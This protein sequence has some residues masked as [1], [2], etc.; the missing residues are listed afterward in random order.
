MFAMLLAPA[1]EQVALERSDSE[2][3]GKLFWAVGWKMSLDSM[4][5]AALLGNGE[6]GSASPYHPAGGLQQQTY[7]DLTEDKETTVL[8]HV[9]V[10]VNG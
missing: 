8:F 5:S 9:F 2:V 4:L 10:R 7:L 3:A 1:G 6:R